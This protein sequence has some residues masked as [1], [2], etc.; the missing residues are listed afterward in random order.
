MTKYD[1]TC[2]VEDFSKSMKEILFL[3][4][5]MKKTPWSKCANN[6]LLNCLNDK[7]NMLYALAE[8]PVHWE[9]AKELCIDIGNFAMMIR[10]NI[11][12]RKGYK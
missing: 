11:D 6:Y 8:N 7:L 5:N 3:V 10:D 1:I 2:D 4:K 12:K 9:H